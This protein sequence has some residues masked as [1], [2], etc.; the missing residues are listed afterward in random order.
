MKP[1]SIAL[2]FH[3]M[4]R[5]AEKIVVAEAIDLNSGDAVAALSLQMMSGWLRKYGYAWRFGS[6]GIYDRVRA[7][8]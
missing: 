1:A 5:D 6:S 3:T 4:E 2:R 8:A 7:A